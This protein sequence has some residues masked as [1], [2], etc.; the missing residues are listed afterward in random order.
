MLIA[1]GDELLV[2]LGSDHTDRKVEAYSIAVS[3]QMCPKPV[4]PGAWRYAD[5]ADHWDSLVLRSWATIGGV[6]L[7]YQEGTVA[8]LLPPAALFEQLGVGSSLP[9]GTAMFGGTL[10]AIGG[11]RPAERLELA[12][13]D[14]VL[15]R[16]LTHSYAI[17]VLPAVS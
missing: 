6:R 16:T 13:E 4:S 11:I 10:S 3:K 5:I 15:G 2:A 1:D 14:P 17:E 7:P 12:L 9:A 8:H